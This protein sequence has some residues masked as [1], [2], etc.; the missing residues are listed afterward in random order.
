LGDSLAGLLHKKAEWA[1]RLLER[2][3]GDKVDGQGLIAKVSI[4]V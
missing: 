2:Q 3:V 4:E 1:N